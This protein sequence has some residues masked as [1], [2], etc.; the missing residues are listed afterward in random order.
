M[1]PRNLSC[2]VASSFLVAAAMLMAVAGLVSRSSAADWPAWRGPTGQGPCPE[3][4]LPL[5][6]NAK[7]TVVW[8]TPLP[9]PGNSSPVVWGDKVILTQANKG[10]TTRSLLCFDRRD[11]KLLWKHEIAYEEKG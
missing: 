1:P 11:G 7:E 10:G 5:K 2:H 8:K 6:W 4:G 9:A 3:E